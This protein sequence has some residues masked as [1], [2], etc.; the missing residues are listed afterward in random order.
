VAGGQRLRA[1]R[2]GAVAAEKDDGL[3]PLHADGAEEPLLEVLHFRLEGVDELFRFRNRRVR[4]RDFAD[5]D[6]VALEALLHPLGADD[7]DDPVSAGFK[8][9]PG[10]TFA[11][12]AAL[13]RTVENVIKLFLSVVYEFS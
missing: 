13:S 11:A 8:N 7:A 10:Q 12:D 2:A 6:G 5:D 4:R 3:V 9:D 1:L